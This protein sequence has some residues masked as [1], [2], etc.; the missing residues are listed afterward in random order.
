MA[1]LVFR[2]S[3]LMHTS[4][5]GLRRIESENRGE[6]RDISATQ[7]EEMKKHTKGS[8]VVLVYD[9]H[10]KVSPVYF[11]LAVR[12]SVVHQGYSSTV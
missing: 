2:K 7:G 12:V 1:S 11:R 4:K 8:V 5:L 9:I 10:R 3:S 6:E